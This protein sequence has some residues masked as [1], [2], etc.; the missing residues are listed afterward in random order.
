V[1]AATNPDAP[2]YE[3][4]LETTTCQPNADLGVDSVVPGIADFRNAIAKNAPRDKDQ[5]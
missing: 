5:L 1:A 2:G 4:P 3:L